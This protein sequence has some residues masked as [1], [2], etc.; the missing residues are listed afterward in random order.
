MMTNS[1]ISVKAG[2]E[3]VDERLKLSFEDR[4]C[5]EWHPA[6]R[7]RSFR[8]NSDAIMQNAKANVYPRSPIYLIPLKYFSAADFRPK[9]RN[10]SYSPQNSTTKTAPCIAARSRS[11]D[12]IGLEPTT[13][14]MSTWPTR[15]KTSVFVGFLIAHLP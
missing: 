2:R 10:R 4:S 5:I 9:P 14:T 6:E 7:F 8:L 3:H 15:S 1:S 12:D 13:S 11:V